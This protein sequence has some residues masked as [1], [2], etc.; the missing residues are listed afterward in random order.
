L[1]GKPLKWLDLEKHISCFSLKIYTSN[2]FK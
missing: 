2:L 1:S